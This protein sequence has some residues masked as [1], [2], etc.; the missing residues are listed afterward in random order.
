MGTSD[1]ESEILL[2]DVRDSRVSKI[3]GSGRKICPRWPP[4]QR[5]VAAL[6]EDQKRLFLYDVNARTWTEA[7]SGVLL[8]G[9]YW[10]GSFLYFQDLLE[11]D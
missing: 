7:A 5:F 1:S 3:P 2:F 6:S 10:S 8:T 9:P 4:D 11:P